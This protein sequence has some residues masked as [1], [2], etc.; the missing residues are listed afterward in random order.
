MEEISTAAASV[1]EVSE[2]GPQARTLLLIV[3]LAFAGFIGRLVVVSFGDRVAGMNPLRNASGGVMILAAVLL[4]GGGVFYMNGH[5]KTGIMIRQH[6]TDPFIVS[7]LGRDTCEV[8]SG[9]YCVVVF[10]E[11]RE[12]VVNWHDKRVH[13]MELLTPP[14]NPPWGSLRPR[15]RS[16]DLVVAQILPEP[17][18]LPVVLPAQ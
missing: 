4:M 16:D 10:E 14:M 17:A 11:E 1:Q 5:V 3:G 12:I 6:V 13:M 9:D 15:P 8:P 2:I 7:V 18:A